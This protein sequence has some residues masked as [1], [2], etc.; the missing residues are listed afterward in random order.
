MFLPGKIPVVGVGLLISVLASTKVFAHNRIVT[1]GNPTNDFRT[2]RPGVVS[3]GD[4]SGLMLASARSLEK[5]EIGKGNGYTL[6]RSVGWA[7][8]DANGNIDIR[9]SKRS[10]CTSAT[11]AAFL[12]TLGQLGKQGKIRIDKPA[13]EALNS[14]LFRDVWNS[15]GYGP[16]KVMELLGGQNFKDPVQA[17]AGDIVKIDR[18]N[19]TGHMVILSSIK[20]GKICYWSSNRGTQGL[21]E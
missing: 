9:G 4:V 17:R 2:A 18:A 7:K 21:G 14:S 12:K 5:N 13:R 3:Q 16:A 20:D 6:T 8:L 19:G 1:F 15:N 10:H 11:H